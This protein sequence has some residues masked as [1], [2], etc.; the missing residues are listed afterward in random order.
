MYDRRKHHQRWCAR[1]G[2]HEREKLGD[3]VK[4]LFVVRN[5]D[6]DT[7]IPTTKTIEPNL[8]AIFRI[9]DSRSYW[10]AAGNPAAAAAK[11]APGAIGAD[12]AVSADLAVAEQV[13]ALLRPPDCSV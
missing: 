12:R 9:C 1:P 2:I 10:S 3:A 13:S 4:V 7:W 6:V 11:I 8:A 5:C